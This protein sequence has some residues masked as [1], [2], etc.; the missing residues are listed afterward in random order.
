[1]YNA[2]TCNT[3]SWARMKE[4]AFVVYFHPNPWKHS[5]CNSLLSATSLR[6]HSAFMLQ[7]KSIT[8]KQRG[9]T[10]HSD[11]TETAR[12][13]TAK[14][15]K[16]LW[17][18][19]TKETTGLASQFFPFNEKKRRE[20]GFSRALPMVA[21]SSSPFSLSLFPASRKPVSLMSPNYK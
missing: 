12:N 6:E 8:C 10:G 4:L 14:N 16:C 3:V 17:P 18:H 7:Q 11:Q 19:R 9:R 1:M 20:K 5:R 13:R 2:L 21:A 15:P